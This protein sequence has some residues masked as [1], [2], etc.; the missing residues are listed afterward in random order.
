VQAWNRTNGDRLWETER[1]K[2]RVLSAPL[3]TPRGILVAD[4]G[5]FCTCCLWPMA[6]CSTV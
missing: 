3:V 1:L 5:G 6:L 4:N 2:Y